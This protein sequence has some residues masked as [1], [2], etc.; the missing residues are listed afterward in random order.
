M[1]RHLPLERDDILAHAFGEAHHFLAAWGERIAAAAALE[2]ARAELLLDLR[3]AAEHGRMIDRQVLRG[4]AERARVG[5]GLHIAKVVPG[6]HGWRL[7]CCNP[8]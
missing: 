6:E 1:A 5:D 3:E 4:A 2:Q 7:R 8:D